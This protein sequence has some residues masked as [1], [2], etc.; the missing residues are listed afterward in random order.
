LHRNFDENGEPKLASLA[1]DGESLWGVDMNGR[2][3]HYSDGI[4]EDAGG[5]GLIQLAVSYARGTIWAVCR[6][7]RVIHRSTRPGGKWSALPVGRAMKFVAVAADGKTVW[8]V[9]TAS[10]VHIY[11]C[12]EN[13]WRRVSGWLE[14]IS[15][16]Y[17]G[18]HICGVN[19]NGEL[20][21]CNWS[22]AK[23]KLLDGLD[24]CGADSGWMHMSGLLVQIALSGNGRHMWGVNRAGQVYYTSDVASQWCRIEG[25]RLQSV[26]SSWDGRAAWGLDHSGYVWEFTV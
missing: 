5:D 19:A 26:L 7:G 22:D 21:R 23:S 24:A 10:G 3:R 1:T 17:D 18:S 15:V 4:W 20:F 12:C 13:A 11:S 16:S 2:A 8:L 6:D 14:Q 9:D 25:G